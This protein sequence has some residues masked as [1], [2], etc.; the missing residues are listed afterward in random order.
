MMIAEGLVVVIENDFVPPLRQELAIH[1]AIQHHYQGL[2]EF[3]ECDP[4]SRF[5]SRRMAEFLRGQ[6]KRQ[7]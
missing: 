2:E 3:C 7:C 5:H 4:V 1:C 6:L